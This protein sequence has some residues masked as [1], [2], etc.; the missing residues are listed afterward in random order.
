MPDGRQA[1]ADRSRRPDCACRVLVID[2]PL[3]DCAAVVPDASGQPAAGPE[4]SETEKSND[5]QIINRF[6]D[7]ENCLNRL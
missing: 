5:I 6:K 7:F 3:H 1:D 2:V 4:R